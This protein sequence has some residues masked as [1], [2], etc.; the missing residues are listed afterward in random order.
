MLGWAV[1]FLLLAL[2]AASFGFPGVTGTASGTAR[3]LFFLFLVM[4]VLVLF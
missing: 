2:V 4:F 1:L 3:T